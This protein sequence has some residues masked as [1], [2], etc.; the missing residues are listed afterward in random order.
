MRK[1]WKVFKRNEKGELIS[2][3]ARGYLQCTYKKNRI[4]K[5]KKTLYEHGFGLAI[6]KNKDDAEWFVRSN[7]T[8]ISMVE[9]WRVEI[10]R[11]LKPKVPRLGYVDTTLK[12]FLNRIKSISDS[13]VYWWPKGT[14]FTDW[15]KPIE[16]R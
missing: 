10:G 3:F 15:V 6:F 9:I 16:R 4:T 1:A 14:M 7:F 5:V 8:G 12:V 2:C 13:D 11:C